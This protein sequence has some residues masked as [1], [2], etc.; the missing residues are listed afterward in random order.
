MLRETANSKILQPEKLMKD[1]EAFVTDL[2]SKIDLERVTFKNVRINFDYEWIH[3]L[4]KLRE[5]MGE[6]EVGNN[7][8][9]GR[10]EQAEKELADDE[11]FASE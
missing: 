11:V 2:F 8:S 5:E 1:G 10:G 9:V 3:Q 7:A 6:A 4:E